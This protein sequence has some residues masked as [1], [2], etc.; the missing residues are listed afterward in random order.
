M[1][2]NLNLEDTEDDKDTNRNIN[3][4]AYLTDVLQRLSTTK[5]SHVADLTPWA[6]RDA[7]AN[8]PT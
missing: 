8:H 3:A 2:L 5:S 4:E 1:G 7:R 6:W